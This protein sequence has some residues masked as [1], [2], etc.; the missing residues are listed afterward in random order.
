VRAPA[1][2]VPPSLRESAPELHAPRNVA[3]RAALAVRAWRRE[4]SEGKGMLQNLSG[5][6]RGGTSDAALAAVVP[7]HAPLAERTTRPPSRVEAIRAGLTTRVPGQALHTGVVA[8]RR[9]LLQDSSADCLAPRDALL[10]RALAVAETSQT[11]RIFSHHSAAALW[12]LPTIGAW[13]TAVEHV[14]HAEDKGL[15]PGVRRRRTE[16]S[17]EPREFAGVWLTSVARTVVDLAREIPLPSA[18][19]AADYALHHGWCTAEELRREAEA[20]PRGHRG[21]RRAILVSNLA[22]SLNESVGESLSRAR[23]FELRIPRPLLQVVRT[24]DEDR[25]DYFWPH[26]QLSG[27]FDGKLKYGLLPGQTGQEAAD[28]LFEEKRREDRIRAVGDDVGRWVWDEAYDIGRF[29]YVVRQRGLRPGD[30]LADWPS[31]SGP[32]KH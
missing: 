1:D 4:T 10:A 2:F 6:G 27:E 29:E 19:A 23:M 26:L 17:V 14:C 22:D 24:P 32:G 18:L 20:I 21:R 28:A 15:S 12:G 31:L 5:V 13:P 30:G 16:R 25:V 7:A 3:A 11:P 9:G 8:I